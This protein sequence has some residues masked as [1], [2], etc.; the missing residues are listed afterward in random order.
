M[1]EKGEFESE[2]DVRVH[3]NMSEESLSPYRQRNSPQ[4]HSDNS[5]VDDSV[6]PDVNQQHQDP[7]GT[8]ASS[9]TSGAIQQLSELESTTSPCEAFVSSLDTIYS[10]NAHDIQTTL[11]KLSIETLKD[12][13]KNC[14]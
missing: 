1:M 3:H 7:P 6:E 4:T 12:Y 2:N 9:S 13:T 11:E 10:Y 14:G 5:D 8:H